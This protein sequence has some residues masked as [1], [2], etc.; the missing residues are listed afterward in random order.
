MRAGDTEA[1][2]GEDETR[3]G[4]GLTIVEAES[5]A[6][7]DALSAPVGNEISA[8]PEL[9]RARPPFARLSSRS[10]MNRSRSGGH[11]QGIAMPLTPAQ[12][13]VPVGSIPATTPNSGTSVG[14]L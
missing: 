4:R 1:G 10:W 13:P 9:L 14:R 11:E 5:R 6:N 8:A 12:L 7:T 3:K 2:D